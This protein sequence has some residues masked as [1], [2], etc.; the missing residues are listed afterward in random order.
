ML[1]QLVDR[2]QEMCDAWTSEFMDCEDVIIYCDDF[3]APETDCIVSPA[4]SFGFMGGGLDGVITRRIGRQTQINVQAV[5]AKRPMKELLVGETILVKTGNEKIPYCI[6][7]PTMRVSMNLKGTP[8]VY[9]A[10][11][12]IF[13]MLKK[14]LINSEHRV[15]GALI[16]KVTISGLG[17]GVGGVPYEV[18]ASQMRQAY[19]DVWLGQETFPNSFNEIKQKHNRIN[20]G[21]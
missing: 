18:C 4:N 9:L 16:K 2:N 3:F 6:S 19:D 8:N 5:I 17:T 10:S 7:A 1:I 15:G 11:K 20:N 21:E 14:T 12:A 13:S